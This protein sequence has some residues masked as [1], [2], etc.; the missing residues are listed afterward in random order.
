AEATVSPSA[1]S[2]AR[3]DCTA[4]VHAIR[5]G[6]N[7]PQT[8]PDP[9]WAHPHLLSASQRAS[10]TP[11]RRPPGS[12]RAVVLVHLPDPLLQVVIEQLLLDVVVC[13]RIPDRCQRAASPGAFPQ[14]P[15]DLSAGGG[16]A[17]LGE[18]PVARRI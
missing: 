15:Y 6:F 8:T 4:T 12:V 7:S 1:P 5:L 14:S 18:H 16:G 17:A 13:L 2:A 9:A 11:A 10:R 3:V